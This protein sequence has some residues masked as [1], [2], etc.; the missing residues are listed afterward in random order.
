MFISLGIQLKS[1]HKSLAQQALEVAL[2]LAIHAI[3][4]SH[5]LQTQISGVVGESRGL[6]I[7][8]NLVQTR[9]LCRFQPVCEKKKNIKSLFTCKSRFLIRPVD[10]PPVS[11]HL[12]CSP[13]WHSFVVFFIFFFREKMRRANNKCETG[14]RFFRVEGDN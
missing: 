4:F 3:V 1:N 6:F 13:Q 2:W 9:W 11:R 5:S 12:E 14:R 10:E 7:S 8:R